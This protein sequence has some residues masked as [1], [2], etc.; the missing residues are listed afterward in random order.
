MACWRLVAGERSQ[1]PVGVGRSATPAGEVLGHVRRLRVVM[2]GELNDEDRTRSVLT[3]AAAYV[4]HP[5]NA[6]FL[7]FDLRSIRKD[8]L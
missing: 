1:P 3:L 5:T 2:A 6:R 8:A 4:D 7:Y